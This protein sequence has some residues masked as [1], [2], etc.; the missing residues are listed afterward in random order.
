MCEYATKAVK[1]EKKWDSISL[2]WSSQIQTGH[3][4]H[5]KE[6]GQMKQMKFNFQQF[7]LKQFKIL[8]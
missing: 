8:P 2:K 7:I 5:A 3:L 4:G 1:E 6:K